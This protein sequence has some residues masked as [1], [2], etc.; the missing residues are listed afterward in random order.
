MTATAIILDL[1]RRGVQLEAAGDKLRFR[2]KKAVPPDLLVLLVQNKPDILAALS[3]KARVRGRDEVVE[4]AGADPC[5]HCKADG[6]C[7][8]ALCGSGAPGMGWEKGPCATCKGAGFL[9]WLETVQ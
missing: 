7:G 1:R 8:C 6:V 3:T 2:P 5:W 9:A 4:S